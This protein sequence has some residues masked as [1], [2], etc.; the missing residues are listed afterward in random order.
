IKVRIWHQYCPTKNVRKIFCDPVLIREVAEPGSDVRCGVNLICRPSRE[1]ASLILD[2]QNRLRH[3]EPDQYYYPLTDLHLTVFEI[4]HSLNC[5][6]A[7][8]IADTMASQSHVWL[9]DVRPFKLQ[10]AVM[11]FDERACALT[12]EATD[13]LGPLRAFLRDKACDLGI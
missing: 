8:A 4:C 10:A 5:K 1:V 2:L 7:E 6:E 9:K 13:T 3:P 12:F 11:A